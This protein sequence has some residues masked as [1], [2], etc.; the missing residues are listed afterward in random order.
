MS[1]Q[2]T[3]DAPNRA[4]FL[5]RTGGFGPPGV[6]WR[7]DINSGSWAADAQFRVRDGTYLEGTSYR[8]VVAHTSSD[9]NR[10]NTV[11][12]EA[13]WRP[14]AGKGAKGDTGDTGDM[15]SSVYDPDNRGLNVFSMDSMQDGAS[16]VAMTAGERSKL[17]GI[18]E[19]ATANSS[20]ENLLDRGNH[21]G[22][23]PAST[24]SDFSTAADQRISA[25]LGSTVQAY[26]DNLAA[27]AGV[28]PG[29]SGLV[30]LA[31]ANQAALRTAAGLGTAAVKNTGTSGDV[32]PTADQ[33][34]TWGGNQMI[35]PA[36]GSAEVS[37]KKAATGA[38]A[39]VIGWTGA[40]QRWRIRMGNSTA[41]SGSNVG[42]D[43]DILRY[44][45]D[46][47]FLS[48]AFLI[49]RATGVVTMQ[50][51]A[52]I[53]DSAGD[54]VSIK[55]TA[56]SSYFASLMSS[57]DGT[58]L[59]AS[60]G[61]TA[62]LTHRPGGWVTATSYNAGDWLAYGGV[63]Y[64]CTV[65]HTSG[66]S[67]EPGVGASWTTRWEPD[68]FGDLG[69]SNVANSQLATMAQ[70]TIKGRGAASGTGVPENLS[71]SAVRTIL[72][73]EAGATANATNAQLR[74]RTTHTGVQAISTITGLQTALDAKMSS[75]FA[76]ATGTI[77]DAR[78]PNRLREAVTA[79]ADA[80]NAVLT[81][82]YYAA[83]TALNL[84]A[85]ELFIIDVTAFS[86]GSDHVCQEAWSISRSVDGSN[87]RRWRREK[88]A[89]VWKSWFRTYGA[90]KELDARYARVYVQ[91]DQPVSAPV[92]AIWLV[93]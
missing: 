59:K 20:D 48:R 3:V 53:G 8:C 40:A 55:G 44:G 74:D 24:I 27:V 66:A 57:V 92:G 70:A 32:V 19:G 23:Q 36:T 10:P 2:L 30:A 9:E 51:G 31:A 81:G 71:A 50:E 25:A 13:Y 6:T 45:D 91:S 67:T 88:I 38:N 83:S 26:S 12:G 72:G 49:D 37:V 56:V 14:V 82:R 42:S 46:G 63:C 29:A 58:A 68:P 18:A 7:D 1:V 60:L 52:N 79:V 21:T 16:R 78:M 90:E 5:Q 34:I 86:S 76:N 89:G 84:P 85:A 62:T 93:P 17:G 33:A 22:S 64:I 54:P 65:A 41:E 80:N 43:F 73:I 39:S 11:G 35:A 61:I 4:I 15:D 28:A 47:T 75:D 69:V 87:A 77:A